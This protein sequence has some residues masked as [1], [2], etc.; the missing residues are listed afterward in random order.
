MLLLNMFIK[1]FVLLLFLILFF[2]INNSFSKDDN[3]NI[4]LA[5][6]ESD[7]IKRCISKGTFLRAMKD[8]NII[9]KIKKLDKKQPERT[10]TFTDYFKMKK[11]VSNK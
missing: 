4:W 7:A 6:L 8:V 11:K 10:I 5:E 1:K 2:S 3:Y 9:E